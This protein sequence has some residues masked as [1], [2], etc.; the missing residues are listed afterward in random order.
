MKNTYK[1]AYKYCKHGGEVAKCEA[2]KVNKKYY[3]ADCNKERE[4]KGQIF[5]IYR[6]YY[7]KNNDSEMMI[8]KTISQLINDKGYDSEYILFVLCQAIRERV[9]L[10]SI[11]GLHYIVNDMKIE[12]KY[13]QYVASKRAKKIIFEDV[14]TVKNKVI[15]YEKKK[16]ETW[17][18]TLFG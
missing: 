13:K 18:D 4:D 8:N 17:T 7:E 15:E 16:K 10:N 3:H 12:K 11:H 1:C 14:E 5:M 9:P 2:V 6:K